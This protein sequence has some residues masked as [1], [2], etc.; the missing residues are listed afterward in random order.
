MSG[1]IMEG[2]TMIQATIEDVLSGAAEIPADVKRIQ[3]M[4][5]ARVLFKLFNADGVAGDFDALMDN[6]AS[7]LREEFDADWPRSCDWIVEWEDA[8]Q[9]QN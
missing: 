8:E 9:A 2:G 1:Q 3:I 7:G 6:S 5:G 4:D